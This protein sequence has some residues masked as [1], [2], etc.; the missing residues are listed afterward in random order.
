MYSFP[1]LSVLSGSQ[2]SWVFPEAKRIAYPVLQITLI[3]KMHQ[4]LSLTN[5]TKVGGDTPAWV[6]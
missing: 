2:I 6:L 1:F 5:R 3:R 4:L